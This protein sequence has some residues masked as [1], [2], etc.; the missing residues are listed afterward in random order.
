MS[1]IKA[2]M[3][4][5]TRAM[6]LG[7]NDGHRPICTE[8]MYPTPVHLSEARR[9]AEKLPSRVGERLYYPDGRVTDLKGF[10][11]KKGERK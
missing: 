3:T 5:S 6:P 4:G 2:V 1:R 10:P 8:P 9:L 7:A 11:L